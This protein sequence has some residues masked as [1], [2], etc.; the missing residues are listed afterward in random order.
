MNKHGGLGQWRIGGP[1]E[2]DELRLRAMDGGLSRI[3][4]RKIAAIFRTSS[5]PQEP[6]NEH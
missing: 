4:R 5:P 1:G 3:V 6:A 2:C